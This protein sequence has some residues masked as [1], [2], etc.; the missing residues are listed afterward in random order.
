MVPPPPPDAIFAGDPSGGHFKLN[1][2]VPS[3]R[4]NHFDIHDAASAILSGR[5]GRVCAARSVHSVGLES[6]FVMLLQI[7]DFV[8]QFSTN[9]MFIAC[10]VQVRYCHRP[11]ML[12]LCD[13]MVRL[14]P[15]QYYK[16]HNISNML[17]ACVKLNMYDERLFAQMLPLI[18]PR[19][20]RTNTA[21]LSNLVWTFA[22]ARHYN[23]HLFDALADT[24]VA[25]LCDCSLEQLS[26][27]AWGMAVV[28]HPAPRFFNHLNDRLSEV[29][30][31]QPAGSTDHGAIGEPKQ[32]EKSLTRLKRQRGS[33]R[34]D[35][36]L[37][38]CTG[39]EASNLLWALAKSGNA[40]PAVVKR[41]LAV[42]EADL[43]RL[44]PQVRQT[45]GH[46]LF[47]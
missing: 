1:K 16:L 47:I 18:L 3:E 4:Q 25:K 38:H 7:L 37:T 15:S 46:P 14:D 26:M 11:L 23:S 44:P 32:L 24:A 9:S 33:S 6:T 31:M 36:R 30:E 21:T 27:V 34:S 40:R 42:C 2:L 5:P 17:W 29:L 28:G 41:L 10:G 13:A 8:V 12:A 35:R 39:L 22:R 20:G 45:G 19:I 43:Q